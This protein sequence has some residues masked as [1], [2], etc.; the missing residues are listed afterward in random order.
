MLVIVNHFELIFV[1][2]IKSVS[3]VFFAHGCPVVLG[4][5][6]ERTIFSH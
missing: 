3:R 6:V 1:V 2:G 4:S 5:F